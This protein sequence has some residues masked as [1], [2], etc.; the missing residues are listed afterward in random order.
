MTTQFVWIEGM[1]ISP[2]KVAGMSISPIIFLLIF[3]KVKENFSV[4]I[5]V[6]IYIVMLICCSMLSS[7]VLVWSRIFYRGLFL[8]TFVCVYQIIYSDEIPID[9]FRRLLTFIVCSYGVVFLL[10]H[11]CFIIGIHELSII[12]L[13]GAMTMGGGLKAN[14]LAIEP[15]HAARILAF[16][17][18]GEI[19]LTEIMQGREMG[20]KEH[21]K[22]N[23]WS[24]ISFWGSML[25]MG[26]A[27]AMLGAALVAIHFFK[28]HI[29][30]YLIAFMIVVVFLNV[31]FHIESVDRLKNV[32]NAFFS[33]DTVQTLK[34]TESSGGSRIAPMVN[35]FTNLNLLSWETWVGAGSDHVRVHA[36]MFTTQKI[37]DIT[38]FGLISYIFS[39]I[40]VFKCCIR[41][42]FCLETLLFAILLGL[43]IGSL[44]TC[45]GAM[46]ICTA[47][48]YFSE[49]EQYSTIITNE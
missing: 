18:W 39:L 1:N 44:Y 22:E 30:I 34:T 3:H 4:L 9:Y 35:T 17:Y 48:K 49:K 8:L 32:I 46:I 15:S 38:D 29:G 6:S 12:N 7:S 24:A 11:L 37:G 42:F 25:S 20:I 28:K 19:A 16:V 13:T 33:D 23:P 43:A 40:F 47:I 27:T 36:N 14:G 5:Y 31:D 45:W 10:Q 21:I 41:K 26:S 2:L